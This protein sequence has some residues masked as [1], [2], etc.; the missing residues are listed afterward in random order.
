MYKMIAAPEIFT[1]VAPEFIQIGGKKRKSTR[2]TGGKSKRRGKG[3]KS[4]RR[5]SKKSR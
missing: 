2:K 4:K 5:R 3:K 1:T